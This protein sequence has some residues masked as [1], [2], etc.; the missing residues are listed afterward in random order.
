[1]KHTKEHDFPQE[2]KPG[3]FLQRCGQIT[4]YPEMLNEWLLFWQRVYVDVWNLIL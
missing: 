2:M 4:G 3:H 1:M